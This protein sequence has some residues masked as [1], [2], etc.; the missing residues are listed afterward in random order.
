LRGTKGMAAMAIFWNSFVAFFLYIT[1]GHWFGIPGAP[2]DD[3]V[4]LLMGV[5]M[6]PFVL[7]GIWL[8]LVV[9]NMAWQSA[10]F[11]VGD[12]ELR[13]RRRSLFRSRHNC[14]SADE[15]RTIRVSPS[16]MKVND[17]P[18]MLLRI[19]PVV[20]KYVNL[21]VGRDETELRWIA[22]MLMTALKPQTT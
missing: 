7:A 15:I 4:S 22:T 21:F 2:Q 12:G 5:L 10:Q 13:V 17:Q 8:I 14:W 19:K 6:I 3:S 1:V 16:S 18:V 9:L 20:G 11:E